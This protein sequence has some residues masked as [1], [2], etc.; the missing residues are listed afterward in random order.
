[1]CTLDKFIAKAQKKHAGLYSYPE[2][3]YTGCKENITAIC[4]IHGEFTQTADSHLQGKGC[5]KCGIE[6]RSSLRR[7]TWQELVSNAISVHG[8]RYSYPKQ[9]YI[10]SA[11]KITIICA[12]H[13]EFKQSFNNHLQG[14]GCPACVSKKLGDR[15]RDSFEGFVRKANLVHDN[16]YSYPTDQEYSI[17]SA[18]IRVICPIH[19]EFTQRPNDHISAG[20]GCR[21]CSNVGSSKGEQS[22]LSAFNDYLPLSNY[23][24]DIANLGAKVTRDIDCLSKIELD[25]YFE[26]QRIAV[27]YNGL[28]WHSEERVGSDYHSGKQKVCKELGIDLIQIFE[29][30]WLLK[31]EIVKSI[32][33]SRLGNY[34]E[35]YYARKTELVKVDSKIAG[36]FY[37]V[38]HIQGK[39]NSSSHYGLSVEGEIVAMASFG[40]RGHLFKN[41]TDIELIRF[42]T[43][44]NTQVV[45]GLSK[46][47]AVYKYVP[48][49]TYCDLRLFNGE[50]YKAAGFEETHVSKP[51]YFY[52]KR[53]L[54]HNRIGFQKHKL[55]DKLDNFDPQQTEVQNMGNNGYLRIF[56]CGSMVLVRQANRPYSP[57]PREQ[58]A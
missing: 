58:T 36:Q 28:Y 8:D 41:N 4:K 34:Q 46:L 53:L 44:L 56:D 7:S 11:N 25:I 13:G 16:F 5:Q 33:N 15:C 29:D 52:V 50:G 17:S 23:K 14:N 3:K 30:E 31:P 18:K 32:I 6:S 26:K 12:E 49:K 40:N 43:K 54:R 24:I 57:L 39:T 55:A 38:N 10:R 9:N 2:Q 20:Q 48:I 27:E 47:L 22:L 37:E 19:G 1:M 51:N 45:G 35:R 21:K 42:C